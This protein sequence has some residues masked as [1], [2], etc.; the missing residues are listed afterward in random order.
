M[1]LLVKPL[2]FNSYCCRLSYGWI[3]TLPPPTISS[4]S[5]LIISSA[6]HVLMPRGLWDV[7]SGGVSGLQYFLL[8]LKISR[9]KDGKNVVSA[10][11]A[12][13]HSRLLGLFSLFFQY[14][15]ID[16][17]F[18]F[19]SSSNVWFLLNLTFIY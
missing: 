2:Q 16:K 4:V 17:T 14:I 6:L 3:L 5:H 15:Q 9:W 11:D 1:N 18:T 19:L 12:F 8:V 13:L 7:L 10:S